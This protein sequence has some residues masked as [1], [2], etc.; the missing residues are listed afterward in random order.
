MI[1]ERFSAVSSIGVRSVRLNRPL[2]KMEQEEVQGSV[3]KNRN[4]AKE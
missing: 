4:S 2:W 1:F 3:R